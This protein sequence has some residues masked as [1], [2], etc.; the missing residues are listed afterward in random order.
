MFAVRSQDIQPSYFDSGTF[1][2]FPSAK[3]LD[4]GYQGGGAMKGFVLPPERAVDIDEPEDLITAE[5]IFWGSQ[6]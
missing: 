3:L 1:V 5:T 2:V 4:E 6:A